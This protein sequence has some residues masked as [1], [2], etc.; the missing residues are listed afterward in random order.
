MKSFCYA[1]NR[2]LLGYAKE[3]ILLELYRAVN[4][5]AAMPDMELAKIALERARRKGGVVESFCDMPVQVNFYQN[6]LDFSEFAQH[7]GPKRLKKAIHACQIDAIHNHP[8]LRDL[9]NKVSWFGMIGKFTNYS[10]C[11]DPLYCGIYFVCGYD[12]E[13][14]QDPNLNVM[15]VV[16]NMHTAGMMPLDIIAVRL[17]GVGA[18]AAHQFIMHYCLNASTMRTLGMMYELPQR[19]NQISIA[20]MKNTTMLCRNILNNNLGITGQMENK[21]ARDN[22]FPV[23]AQEELKRGGVDPDDYTLHTAPEK[24]GLFEK[25]MAS[26][27]ELAAVTFGNEKCKFLVPSDKYSGT[28]FVCV[29]QLIYLAGLTSNICAVT[30]DKQDAQSLFDNFLGC[31]VLFSRADSRLKSTFL[32][33]GKQL[34]IIQPIFCRTRKAALFASAKP[35]SHMVKTH[36]GAAIRGIHV[37][38]LDRV[39]YLCKKAGIDLCLDMPEQHFLHAASAEDFNRGNFIC[40]VGIPPQHGSKFNL[41]TAGIEVLHH[42]CVNEEPAHGWRVVYGTL[43]SIQ[44]IRTWLNANDI[45]YFL[46]KPSVTALTGIAAKT[47]FGPGRNVQS[48]IMIVVD[49][50]HGDTLEYVLLKAKFPEY[51]QYSLEDVRAKGKVRALACVSSDLERLFKTCKH[52]NIPICFDESHVIDKHYD[53]K[54]G[55]NTRAYR[56]LYPSANEPEIIS[57]I[58]QIMN[59][60]V[61]DRLL[62]PDQLRKYNRNHGP[63]LRPTAEQIRQQ[64]AYARQL[65]KDI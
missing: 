35:F 30:V 51:F 2:D 23:W 64:E 27:D 47:G 52:Y 54:V 32:F 33:D 3:N 26:L 59:M 38:D 48:S 49:A 10:R 8:Y 5:D 55:F 41:I 50:I 34:D 46:A 24:K 1:H 56:L 42:F 31:G 18:Y 62:P 16:K 45:R 22:F 63:I 58:E 7:H 36:R 43:D 9:E 29:K 21:I 11:P 20:F 40:T 44:E 12:R 39:V 28:N 13:R 60:D 57:M 25:H 6:P 14:V 15:Q 17:T 61:N 19:L 65:L 53:K 37:E 4:P